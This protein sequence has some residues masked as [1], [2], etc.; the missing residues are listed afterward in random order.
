MK[1]E[2]SE[3]AKPWA[4]SPAGQIVAKE[5]TDVLKRAPDPVDV[6]WD[7]VE[8]PVGR[9]VY[10]LTLSGADASVSGRFVPDDVETTKEVWD[11]RIRLNR[12]W[13][14]LLQVW[15]HRQIAEMKASRD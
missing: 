3:T 9:P 13:R 5:L 6:R 8:D 15:I 2:Y 11:R 12:V 14:D 1:I 4:N 10:E 7:R